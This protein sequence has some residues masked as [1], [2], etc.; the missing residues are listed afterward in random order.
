M[1]T[2]AVIAAYPALDSLI[3]YL[4]AI[5]RTSDA[6]EHQGNPVSDAQGATLQPEQSETIRT[7]DQ[8]LPSME[9]P[10]MF[11]SSVLSKPSTHRE[12]TVGNLRFEFYPEGGK[13]N[14]TDPWGATASIKPL[15]RTCAGN[16]VDLREDKDNPGIFKSEDW[17]LV[18][19][20][21]DQNYLQL[22]FER[23]E[24]ELRLRLNASFQ[25]ASEKF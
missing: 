9:A 15:K 23:G 6:E 20:M 7:S 4:S 22:V 1:S 14:I 21:S 10:T 18:I 8:T 11:K 19:N 16:D 13:L 25:V 17:G 2:D 5:N 12:W 3:Q 24:L